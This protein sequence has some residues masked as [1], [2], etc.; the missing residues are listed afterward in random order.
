[1][2]DDE[3]EEMRK[4]MD[5]SFAQAEAALRKMKVR[6]CAEHER[7]IEEHVARM[8][9][10]R[11]VRLEARVTLVEEELVRRLSVFGVS[12]ERREHRRIPDAGFDHLLDLEVRLARAELHA[13]VLDQ[14]G[15]WPSKPSA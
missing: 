15:L 1:M 3:H 8:K 11:Y 10:E 14:T 9:D 4:R 2:T 13:Q 12:P 7:R 6:R 5:A